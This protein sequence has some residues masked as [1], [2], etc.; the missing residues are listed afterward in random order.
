[1]IGVDVGGTFTDVV[2]LRNGRIETAKVSTN[3]AD[4]AS[5][6]LEGGRLLRVAESDSFNHASTHGLN[7]VITRN[8]PKIGFLTTEGHRDILDMGRVWRPAAAMLDPHWRRSFGDASRPLVPRYLRRGIRERIMASGDVLIELDEEQARAELEVLKRVGIEGVAIC[9]LHAYHQPVHERRLRELV[10]EILGDIPCSVS[11]EVSPLA[12]E[13]AR[14]STTVIDACMKIIYRDYTWRLDEGLRADGF[15]GQLNFADCAATLVPVDRAME[16]PYRVVFSGPSAGTVAS[17]HFGSIIGENRLLCADVGGTSC[18]ISLVADGQPFVNTTFELEHDLVVNALATDITAIGAGGG[19]IISIGK[20]GEVLVGPRS[21]GSSPGPACY[22]NGGTAPT[23]TD[24]FVMIGIL[25]GEQFAGGQFSL[26]RELARRAFEALD[27]EFS[28]AQRVSYAFQTAVENIAEG[29][30]NVAIKNGVDP[31]DYSLI[32]YGAAGPMLLPAALDTVKCK[33]VIVPPHPGLFSALGLLSADR[34]YAA[35][36]SEYLILG[37]AAAASID[38]IFAG[39]E[40]ELSTQVPEGATVTFHRTF[41]G[42]LFGQSWDTPFVDVPA[43]NID[44]DAVGAMVAAF[45]DTYAQRAGTRFDAYPVQGVTF[46]VQAVLDTE[47]VQYPLLQKREESSDPLSPVTYTTLHYLGDLG[48][49][50][51]I[52]AS[53]Y[54]R[55]DL[56]AGDELVGP[57]IVREELSTTFVPVDYQLVVGP[58]AELIIRKHGGSA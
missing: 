23:T 4:V 13:Y 44:E 51:D 20:A 36:R 10:S 3:Y 42:H 17:A 7:A 35:S 41:D 1:M 43:G 27:S 25:D 55:E 11:S 47:K 15:T 49:N 24:T 12:K 48:A 28:L 32:A 58:H 31:R 38:G 57:A 8:L 40:R 2:A 18:D 34:V 19:S 52:V 9:L 54:R 33:E 5:S 30:F 53:V 6:V 21:A 22:G 26:D 14:A 56:R 50:G 37:P 16:A 45:H 39:L 46:R 29:L